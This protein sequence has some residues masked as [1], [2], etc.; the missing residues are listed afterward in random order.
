MELLTW[1]VTST[2]HLALRLQCTINILSVVAEISIKFNVIFLSCLV[3]IVKFVKVKLLGLAG[4]INFC[5]TSSSTS[6]LSE[7]SVVLKPKQF[8]DANTHIK[9]FTMFEQLVIGRIVFLGISFLLQQSNFFATVRR[10]EWSAKPILIISAMKGSVYMATTVD[11]KIAGPNGDVGFLSEYQSSAD[12]DMGFGDFLASVDV[13][14]M[15]RRSF[16]KVLSFGEEVWPYGTTEVV[17]WSRQGLHSLPKHLKET[18]S[19]SNMSPREIF[20]DLEGRGRKH[21]YIDGGYT[22]QNFLKAHLVHCMTITQ[23]PLILG[24][25]VRLFSDDSCCKLQ[26]EKTA[27]FSNGLVKNTYR[28]IGARISNDKDDL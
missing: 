20:Q 8:A 15:G 27:A 18:V 10:N 9:G 17:V 28:V 22:V 25:G 14:I 23:V 7:M 26:L 13:I 24:P 6:T 11:G 5:C 21:A 1:N 4:A 19:W 3:I 2:A 16:E 12:G